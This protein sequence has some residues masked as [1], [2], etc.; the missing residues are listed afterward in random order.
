MDR[1]QAMQLFVRIVELGSFSKAAEQLGMSRASATA[2]VK[3]LESHLGA[4]LLQRTTRQVSATLDGRSYYQ[5]CL[6]I[7][8]EIE[9]AESVFSRSAQHPRGHLKVDLPASLGRLVVI[10]ALPE[11]YARYPEITLEIGIGDRMIDLVREG[12]DCVV[13]IG[14]LDDSTLVARALPPLRQ[15]TCASAGYVA[16]HGLPSSLDQLEGHQ[17][18]DYLSA[19]SGRLQPL[20]FS[21][22]GRVMPYTLPACLAVSNGESY[23]AACEAGLGIVQVPHYHV[24]RQLAAGTLIE[25]LSQHRPPP[26]PMT[27][28]YPHHRHLTPRLRVFIDWLVELFGG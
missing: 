27:V 17:C 2:L 15:L 19:T 14:A 8:A 10:P 13:R 23:V 21:V 12:V 7:L 22:D 16:R 26:L 24:Q 11:F 28:L 5:H 6:S 25:L 1:L 3:Q 20:E 18:V 4:R 9:E